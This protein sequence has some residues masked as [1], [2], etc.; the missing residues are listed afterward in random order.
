MIEGLELPR[1]FLPIDNQFA[2]VSQWGADGISG[3]LAKVDLL[4]KKVVKTIAIGSGPEKMLRVGNTVLVANGGGYGVDSTVVAIGTSDDQIIQRY[5]ASGKNP[6]SMVLENQQVRQ[7]GVS[8]AKAITWMR[9]P[10][11]TPNRLIGRL[12]DPRLPGTAVTALCSMTW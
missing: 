4:S 9:S 3:S 12:R 11:G 5:Y 10:T 1:F 8:S 6:S 7:S 2:Y